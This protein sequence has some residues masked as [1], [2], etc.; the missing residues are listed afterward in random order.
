VRLRPTWLSILFPVV[1]PFWALSGLFI[2]MVSLSASS[3][4][5]EDFTTSDLENAILP[6]EQYVPVEA[7]KLAHAKI[8]WVNWDL[9]KAYGIDLG[10]RELT[11]ELEAKLLNTFAWGIPSPG[12]PAGAFTGERKVV[13]SDFYGGEY[14][15]DNIGS[16]RAASFLGKIPVQSKALGRVNEMVRGTGEGHANGRAPIV[17]L[18][19]EAV[20]GEVNQQLP[21]GAN[22]VFL[23]MDRGTKSKYPGGQSHQDGIVIREEPLRP[24]QFMRLTGMALTSEQQKRLDLRALK[25]LRAAWGTS[26]RR[27][28]YVYAESVAAQYAAA[29]A[30]KLYHGGTSQSNI[31]ISGR[32]VD[33]GTET[34]QAGF[35]QVKVLDFMEPAGK[36]AQIES[37]LIRKFIKEFKNRFPTVKV[38]PIGGYVQAFRAAYRRQIRIEFLKLIGYSMGE[39]EKLARTSV[40]R[41][42]ADSLRK[43]AVLGAVDYVGRYNP[44]EKVTKYDFENVA[45]ALARGELKTLD[46]ADQK[47][48]LQTEALYLEAMEIVKPSGFQEREIRRRNESHPELYRWKMMDQDSAAIARYELDGKAREIQAMIDRRVGP[49]KANLLELRSSSFKRSGGSARC[50]QL[51]DSY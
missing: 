10:P 30:A 20:F 5:L 31:E 23:L 38:D 33:Y 4:T 49:T 50:E 6:A 46:P 2:V 40:G 25:K 45:L 14:I 51:F 11:P 15:G 43:I 39:S 28:F 47:L 16:G 32:F 34:A 29:Y 9:F 35:G 42:L 1:N 41:S 18:M 44:P 7:R 21:R 36:T 8:L 24:A 26:P 37:S 12:D 17:E 3:A 13:Y 22:R 19:R 48:F 27:G